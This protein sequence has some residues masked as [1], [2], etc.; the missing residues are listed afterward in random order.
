VNNRRRFIYLGV[1]L[2]FMLQALRSFSQSTAY[3]LSLWAMEFAVLVLIAYEVWDKIADRRRVAKRRK[4]I[5]GLMN[6]GQAIL[7]DV[8]TVHPERVDSWFQSAEAWTK[9]TQA[10][11]EGYS[12]QALTAFNHLRL[13][14]VNYPNV[15]GGA[16][17]SYKA[18]IA[19]L[20]NLRSIMEKP[21]VY[22]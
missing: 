13:P 4:I 6:E 18:L 2:T 11:L 12:S 9:K 14:T 8:P 15:C 3:L 10:A 17:Q 19:K 20:D 5:F 7:D 22:Y 16:H 1:V 21:E